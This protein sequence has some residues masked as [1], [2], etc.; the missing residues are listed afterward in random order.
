MHVYLSTNGA[1]AC[2]SVREA[3][4]ASVHEKSTAH[5]QVQNKLLSVYA[6]VHCIV[7]AQRQVGMR[8]C[9]AVH[10]ADGSRT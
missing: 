7:Y 10:Y 3:T 8:Y 9:H 2:V 1:R 5:L 4:S 6:R